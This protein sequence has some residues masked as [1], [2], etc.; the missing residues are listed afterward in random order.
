M[1]YTD[2]SDEVL[3]HENPYIKLGQKNGGFPF[4]ITILTPLILFLPKKFDT[5]RAKNGGLNFITIAILTPL[6]LI[7]FLPKKIGT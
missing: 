4:I 2:P 3:T 5:F 1:P 6:A 7:E